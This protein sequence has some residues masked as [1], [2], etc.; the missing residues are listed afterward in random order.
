[1]DII[2]AEVTAGASKAE[3]V[4]I[5]GSVI[6]IPNRV[7]AAPAV[8]DPILVFSSSI[9]IPVALG[10]SAGVVDPTVIITQFINVSNVAC[11]CATISP[12]ISISGV[13]VAPVYRSAGCSIENPFVR[14]P[15]VM[16]SL[17]FA[18]RRK[19]V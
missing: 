7:V 14:V 10:V 12:T 18:R 16:I 8:I 17:G 5:Y 13:S 6:I 3:P 2:P 4:F 9:D 11:S 15:K 1:M 19:Y